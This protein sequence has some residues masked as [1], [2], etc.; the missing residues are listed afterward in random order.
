[1]APQ[2]YTVIDP[3]TDKILGRH[4]LCVEAMEAMAD[5]RGETEVVPDHVF[6]DVQASIAEMY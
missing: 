4:L 6:D 5:Y 3:T 1:M 2:L